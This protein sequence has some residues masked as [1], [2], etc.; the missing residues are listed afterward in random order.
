MIDISQQVEKMVS[1][2]KMKRQNY[3]I[4]KADKGGDT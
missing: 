1:R 2:K 4:S 3:S